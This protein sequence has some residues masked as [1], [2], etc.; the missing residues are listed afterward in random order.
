MIFGYIFF[1]FFSPLFIQQ[2]R[3]DLSNARLELNRRTQE[4]DS[5]KSLSLTND[6][7]QK[8][9]PIPL[10][11]I[12][13]F[14]SNHSDTI[15]SPKKDSGL[16]RNFFFFFFFSTFLFFFFFFFFL[17]IFPYINNFFI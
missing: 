12:P 7:P 14:A 16:N 17:I 13:S 5:Y 15:L 9:N 11:K 10:E 2:L 6:K 4:I 3:S 1:F 8:P